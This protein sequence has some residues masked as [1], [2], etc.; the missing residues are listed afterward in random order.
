MLGP[1]AR[2][3]AAAALDP[4][5]L[6]DRDQLRY[7]NPRDRHRAVLAHPADNEQGFEGLGGRAV[8]EPGDDDDSPFWGW[9]ADMP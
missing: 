8:C 6:Q 7:G 3:A 5:T 4:D 9:V 1:R 2:T